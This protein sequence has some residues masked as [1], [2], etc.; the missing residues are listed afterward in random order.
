MPDDV[1]AGLARETKVV[2][3]E[4]AAT[5]DICRR[6]FESFRTS[7]LLAAEWSR[8]GDEAF[9]TARRTAFRL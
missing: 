9:M 5:D 8:I 3:E 4:T 1:I 2:L 7:I 6:V